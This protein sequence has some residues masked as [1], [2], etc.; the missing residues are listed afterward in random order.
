MGLETFCLRCQVHTASRNGFLSAIH[1]GFFLSCLSTPHLPQ[2][3]TVFRMWMFKAKKV[4]FNCDLSESTVVSV[5]PVGSPS[6][7]EDVAV[8]VF[9]KPTELAHIFLF[10]SC[11][12]FCL[13]GPFNFTS[14]LK[15][16]GQ[17][18]PLS[19]CS[20][21]PISALLVFSTM[22]LFM[23]VSFSPDTYLCG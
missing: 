17:I 3:C 7:G 9:D 5:L 8:Y 21:G 14:F 2:T 12:C 19:L 23:K 11:V 13:E 4:Y 22:C 18:F 16:S 1:R 10:C 20:S 6:H 15:F